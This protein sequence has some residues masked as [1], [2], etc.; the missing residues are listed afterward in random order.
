MKIEFYGQNCP[1]D[2]GEKT[3][4]LLLK[5]FRISCGRFVEIDRKTD[6]AQEALVH[7]IY[8]L[9]V[10]GVF[11]I[12]LPISLLSTISGLAVSKC[13]HSYSEKYKWYQANE[14][15]KPKRRFPP[16]TGKCTIG[17][18]GKFISIYGNPDLVKEEDILTVHPVKYLTNP[19]DKTCKNV[20][21]IKEQ[22]EQALG[23]TK[24][25]EHVLLQQATRSCVPTC[26]A[27]L[28]LDRGGSPNYEAIENT[29]L[30][31]DSQAFDW[32]SEA[33]YK[34]MLTKLNKEKIT[35]HLAALIKEHGSGKLG[36]DHPDAGFHAVVLDAIS[37]E[38]QTAQIRDPYHG[39][40]ITI[41]LD[42]L[43]KMNPE[44][45]I[46]IKWSPLPTF[47]N[48]MHYILGKCW[49]ELQKIYSGNQSTELLLK[50]N[51]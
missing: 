44:D 42:T 37:L 40:K 14:Y 48:K 27:M 7:K 23:I 35:Q 1:K 18:D 20:S 6:S 34:P 33:G 39:W 8:Q 36:I 3:S 11:L 21:S 25:G 41:T 16:A 45:F 29:D 46:Q 4:D 2:F 26:I 31:N 24:S 49:N 43:L 47:V 30:A 15:T 51:L 38:D 12:A 10:F 19:F 13:S 50:R 28:I 9:V 5:P 17:P 32:I 22:V